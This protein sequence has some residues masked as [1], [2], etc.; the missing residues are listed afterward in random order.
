MSKPSRQGLRPPG[1]QKPNVMPRPARKPK[2]LPLP[3]AVPADKPRPTKAELE[4]ERYP[5]LDKHPALQRALVLHRAMLAGKSREEA[6]ALADQKVGPR[7]PHAKPVKRGKRPA[8]P[9]RQRVPP[10]RAKPK[11]PPKGSR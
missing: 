9:L 3:E 4:A 6:E 5:G 1:W 2:R 7:A 8:A 11:S 10:T